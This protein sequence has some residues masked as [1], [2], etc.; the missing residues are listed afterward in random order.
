VV[1]YLLFASAPIFALDAQASFG[2]RGLVALLVVAGTMAALLFAVGWLERRNVSNLGLGSLGLASII[3]PAALF[4]LTMSAALQGD[5]RRPRWLIL[6]GLILALLVS[7]GTRTTIVLL[8]APLA[9]ALGA[10]RQLATRSMRLAV[11]A[12]VTVTA[13]LLFGV[14]FI[15][16]GGADTDF[17][18][19]RLEILRATGDTSED[20]SYNERREQTKIAW[21]R[22]ESAPILGAGPGTTFEWKTQD[23]LRVSS[24]FL[25]TPLVFPAKFGLLGL[26]VF[27]FVIAKYW[28]FLRR[29][30]R[31]EEVGIGQ[32][33]LTGYLAVVL[34]I[35]PLVLPF[36]DKGFSFGLILVLALALQ[37][38]RAK[39]RAPLPRLDSRT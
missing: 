21:D 17:L 8:V 20:A 36:D 1:P 3:M 31:V 24:S 26:A 9:I 6:A 35:T 11:L 18:Q 34:A 32:L 12:P 27:A 25:D 14:A 19:K 33:A 38:A 37:E 13:T 22:F 5:L 23:G 7:T 39:L 30:R 28:S 4:S 2:R 16:I 10:R 15:G 29:L